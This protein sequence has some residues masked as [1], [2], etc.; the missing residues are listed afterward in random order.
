MHTSEELDLYIDKL[1]KYGYVI[2]PNI[3]T[4]TELQTAKDSFNKWLNENP[5]IKDKHNIM[6]PHGIFKFHEVGHQRH[7]W[8]IRTREM[9]QNVF[10]KIWKTEELVV[11]FDGSCWMN[12]ELSKTDKNWT[13][14]DQASNKIGVHCYQG[15]VSLTSN[16]ERTL[17]VYEES[18]NLHEPYM[19]ERNLTDSKNW[20]KIDTDYLEK[21]KESRRVLEVD[22]GSLVLWDSRTF[23]QNQYG[24]TGEER[25]VQ[26]V[27]YLPKEKRSNAMKAKRMKYFIERRTTSHWAYPVNVNGLQPQVYGDKTKMID[28]S[29]LKV[30]DLEDLIEDITKLI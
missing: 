12:K 16:K 26:Y 24:K 22:E 14:T 15:F 25:I 9:V 29:T 10:K 5:D 17:V 27:S 4:K 3:L 19:K 2:V 20:L 23:H 11:S 30:P 7:A 6:S 1:K 18:H 13:H 28:Y 21:I 8:Y